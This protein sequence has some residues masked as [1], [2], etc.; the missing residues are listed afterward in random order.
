MGFRQGVEDLPVQELVAQRAVEALAIA[1]VPRAT[2]R[3]VERLHAY[4][5]EPLLDSAGDDV[6]PDMRWWSAAH[7]QLGQGGEH[8]LPSEPPCHRQGQALTARFVDDREDPELTTVVGAT[9]DKVVRPH[10]PR[11]LGG[12]ADARTV[13][14]PEP[15]PL[16]EAEIVSAGWH[17]CPGLPS[18]W[19]D[20][21]DLFSLAQGVWRLEKGSGA[22]DDGS[23]EGE[24]A[25]VPGG[26]GP[27]AGQA[28][29]DEDSGVVT[30]DMA[31]NLNRCAEQACNLSRRPSR[32]LIPDSSHYRLVN[33]KVV[34]TPHRIGAIWNA[35]CTVIRRLNRNLRRHALFDSGVRCLRRF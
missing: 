17:S 15:S 25:P 3:D 34:I 19:R 11:I 9:L 27:D 22:A 33:T 4:L 6:G 32:R 35:I 26:I 30:A 2:G 31:A 5:A 8:L 10:M 29:Q 13:I 28:D 16:R 21:T 24:P 18:D 20:R 12:Q 1:V 7:K 14:R 23:R